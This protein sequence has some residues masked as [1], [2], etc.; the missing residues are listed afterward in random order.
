VEEKLLVD[1][2]YERVNVSRRQKWTDQ[3]RSSHGRGRAHVSR[4]ANRASGFIL[5]VGVRVTEGL[6]DEYYRQHS[7]SE[8]K[9]PHPVTSRLASVAHFDDYTLPQSPVRR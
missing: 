8:S 7:H 9:H 3:G 1:R 6:R 2:Y 4:L 5:P